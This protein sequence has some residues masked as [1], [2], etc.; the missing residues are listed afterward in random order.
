MVTDQTDHSAWKIVVCQPIRGLSD[1]QSRYL[2]PRGCDQR[3]VR[4]GVDFSNILRA[5]FT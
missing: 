4:P 1:P 3:K 2:R 5:A